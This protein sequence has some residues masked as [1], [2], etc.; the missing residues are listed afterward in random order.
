MWADRIAGSAI[1]EQ[2][3]TSGLGTQEDIDA[4]A[5]AWREWA[6]HPDGWISIPR[7]RT[8]TGRSP[9]RSP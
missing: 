1:T 5:A 3:L 2:L 4:I 7:R 9:R 8:R 6:A